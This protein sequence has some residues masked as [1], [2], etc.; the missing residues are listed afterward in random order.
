MPIGILFWVL[1]VLW[2]VLGFTVGAG[3]PPE[4]GPVRYL[5]LWGGNLLLFILLFIVGYCLFGF[6]VQ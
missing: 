1:M 6:V 4:N 2:L 3:T 5:Y